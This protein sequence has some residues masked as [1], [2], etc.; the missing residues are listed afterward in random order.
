[1]SRRELI[2]RCR[3]ALPLAHC[4]ALGHEALQLVVEHDQLGRRLRRQAADKQK[5]VVDPYY[6]AD[7]CIYNNNNKIVYK[8]EKHYIVL[9][10]NKQ[11]R[12]HT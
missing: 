3:R 11:N 4:G 6:I 8:V 12:V 2:A 10:F 1:L 7:H 5:K 9:G